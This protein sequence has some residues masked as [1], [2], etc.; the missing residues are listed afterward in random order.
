[1]ALNFSKIQAELKG[2][3]TGCAKITLIQLIDQMSS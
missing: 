2:G 3:Q 1:M